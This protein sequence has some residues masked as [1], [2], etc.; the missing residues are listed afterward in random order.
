MTRLIDLTGRRFGKLM[1]LRRGPQE[2]S[3]SN[4][5]WICQCDCGNQS[6]VYA[7]SLRKGST[8]S[9]NTGTCRYVTKGI[10]VRFEKFTIPEPNSGCLLWLGACDSNH[11]GQLRASKHV[12]RRA[13]HIA[14]ELAGRPLPDG[15]VA[16]HSC[17]NTYCVEETH[18]FHGTQS[19]NIADMIRKNR[20]DHSG[21]KLGRGANHAAN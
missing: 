14:L 8:T 19:E 12:L 2:Y 13:T 16:C 1:V 7:P 17:D 15:M 4:A 10:K 3:S 21:L 20:H 11:Y 5:M 9:C 6:N 18:L